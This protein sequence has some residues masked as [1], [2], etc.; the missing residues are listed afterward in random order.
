MATAG[1]PVPSGFLVT[2][3]AYRRAVDEN[4][5]DAVI[6]KAVADLSDADPT[7]WERAAGTIQARFEQATMPAEV[8]Q[9]AR[10]A[11][12]ALAASAG[13]PGG[14]ELA[15]A[16]RSSATA[17]DL[18]GAS[19]AGQQETFLNVRG[20][21]AL[22]VAIRRCW[23]SLWT[24]R[25]LAYR[26]RLGIEHRTVAMAVVVQMLVPADVAGVLFTA[27]PTTGERSELL[28][29]ASFGLGEAIV[30]GQVTPDTYTVD[31]AT[32]AVTARQIGA[33]A[34]MIVANTGT[35]T[36]PGEGGAD[37][38]IGGR[39][40]GNGQGTVAQ[41][42][43]EARRGEAAL[44]ESSLRALVTLALEVER[45]FEW[46]P[47]D[48]EWAIADGHCWLLQA[49]PITGLPPAPLRDV[50]WEPPVPGSKWIRRQVVEHMP[51]PLSPL[52]D[53]LYLHEG[54]DRSADSLMPVLGISGGLERIMDRP[55]FATVNGYAYMRADTK[56]SAASVAL[57]ARWIAVAVPTLFRVAIPYWHDEALPAY[58]A[59]AER[60]KGQDD[61]ALADDQLLAGV[62]EL[63]MADARYWFAAA[64][65]I[66]AAKLTDSL[67][68]GF[69]AKALPGRRLGSGRF[70]QALSDR[71]LEADAALERIAELVRGSASLR[72]LV[73]D[74]PPERLREAM[75]ASAAAED[76]EAKREADTV[77]AALDGYF[78]RF[79]HLIYSLDFA[80][81]TQVDDP[82]PVLV[83]LKALA[84][85]PSRDP[86]IRFRELARE[87]AELT[88]ATIRSLDPIRRRLFKIVLG[89]ARKYAPYRE[90]ALFYVGAA[91]PTLR[92]LA[93]ELGRRLTK[94][95]SLDRPDDV[96]YLHAT[97]LEAASAA[98]G[99]GTGRPDLARLA[100]E[101]RDLRE[102]RKR[103]VPPPAVPPAYQFTVGPIDLSARESVRRNAEDDST[104][105]G[106]A[107][108]PGRVTAP[109]SVILS[110]ADFGTMQ[111]GTVLVCPTT[112]PAWTPLFSQA[113]ALVTDIGGVLAHGSIVAREYGIPAVMGTGIATRRITSG[114]QITVDGDA[115][116]VTLGPA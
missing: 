73:A 41:T 11:Y 51:E 44:S 42:V 103:L 115:G 34:T 27:N 81:P 54:L 37:E 22:L 43:P 17:E 12:A 19:F 116:T 114:Q 92:R 68:D 56:L 20:E 6:A 4:D 100:H 5:L 46:V 52:F 53:E 110:P 18:P 69:L 58:L 76:P 7:S 10:E 91:W 77:L 16:V 104:L 98:R 15:V 102:A 70:L 95:G 8:A 23:A 83:T 111:A 50:R 82:L 65:T 47:Q 85:G 63:T 61:G 99:A 25:A 113:R 13:E 48:V 36:D 24:A 21:A 79:G 112:T 3:E 45:L 109:A 78:E 2:T 62:R 26:H 14:S 31:R 49:R 30:S 71:G 66:G 96:F 90:E 93:L 9:A 105:R 88:R 75:A 87:R 32:G 67:L 29:N 35:A 84:R 80:V 57:L 107:V 39:N 101:R 86:E 89:W 72:E 40:D 106:F 94:A 55:L 33:K 28:V 97:E 74:T 38:S 60:W 64:L 59:T 1:L 108:S